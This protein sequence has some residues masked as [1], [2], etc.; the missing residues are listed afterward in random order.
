MYWIFYDGIYFSLIYDLFIHSF[1]YW[2]SKLNFAWDGNAQDFTSTCWWWKRF[3]PTRSGCASTPLSAGVSIWRAI[4]FAN[5][6]MD[7]FSFCYI[8]WRYTC[9]N[10]VGRFLWFVMN[11]KPDNVF[12]MYLRYRLSETAGTIC[13]HWLVY[14]F[15]LKATDWK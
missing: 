7:D 4:S 2:K 1:L 10:P 14:P 3:R 11:R 9:K 6:V 5:F 13:C 8:D 12:K 15:S